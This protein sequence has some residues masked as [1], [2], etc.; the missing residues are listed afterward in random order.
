MK[1]FKTDVWELNVCERRANRFVRVAGRNGNF[2]FFGGRDS[3]KG[4]F[5]LFLLF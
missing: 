1:M 4:L 3:G 5:V 2:N